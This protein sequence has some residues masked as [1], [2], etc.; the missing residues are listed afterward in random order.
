[1][2][3][4]RIKR[5]PDVIGGLFFIALGASALVEALDYHIPGSIALSPALFPVLAS[6]VLIGL[7]LN[8]IRMGIKRKTGESK[9]AQDRLTV[10][11]GTVGIVF[12]LCLLYTAALQKGGFV[13][14]TIAYLVI[15][16]IVLGEK[17]PAVVAL[18]PLATAGAIYFF[19]EKVL[20]VMLP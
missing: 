17:R 5:S 7:A 13:V 11:A 6:T 15:F 4:T 3:P 8:Q 10:K 16:L 1:M 14:T 9:P 18:V 19:F 20:S 2:F 12:L